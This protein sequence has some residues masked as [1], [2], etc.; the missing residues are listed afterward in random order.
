MLAVL[1]VAALWLGFATA[2]L[3]SEPDT[4][5]GTVTSATTKSPIEGVEV[6]AGRFVYDRN[7]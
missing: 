3:A 1:A 5:A 6:C 4:I 2:A 7:V